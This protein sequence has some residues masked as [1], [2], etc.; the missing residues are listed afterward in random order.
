MNLAQFWGGAAAPYEIEQSLRFDGSNGYLSRTPGSAGNLRTWT[1]SVWLKRSK[2]TQVGIFCPV[3]GGDGSN[4]SQLRIKTDNTFQVYDSGAAVMNRSSTQLFRDPSAW[5]HLVVAV[6][7]TQATDTNRVKIYVNGSQIEA[8]GLLP[9]QNNDLGWNGT[10]RHDIGRYAAGAED[11]F[12]GYMAEMHHVDGTQLDPDSFGEFDDNG[13]WRPIEYTGSYGTNGFYLKF[14]PSA[15]NGIGHDH[16]GNGNNFTATGFNT[17]TG[18]G[19]WSFGTQRENDYRSGTIISGITGFTSA[20]FSGTYAW[21]GNTSGGLSNYMALR[22]SSNTVIASTSVSG[23][24]GSWS[25]TATG[26]SISTTYHLFISASSSGGSYM[27]RNSYGSFTTSYDGRASDTD[28][29][30]DTPTTNWATLN[31]LWPADVVESEGNLHGQFPNAPCKML[32]TMGMTSGKYYWEVD[33]PSF[34]AGGNHGIANDGTPVSGHTG[35][36]ANSWAYFSSGVKSNND[37]TASYGNSWTGTDIIGVAFDAD[38][39]NLYFYKNGTVQNSGT[40]AY[41]GL[42]NGPYYPAF[43][44]NS[45]TASSTVKVNFGQRDFAYTPPTGFNALN[46]A[47]LPAPTVKDG[48]DHFNTVTYAGNGGS[49]TITTGMDH[50]SGGGLL[51]I[52]NRTTTANHDVLDNVRGLN[53]LLELPSTA[54]E[55]TYTGSNLAATSTGYTLNTSSGQFNASSNNYVAWNWLAGG[56]GSSNTD[57]SITSTVSANPTAGFSIGTYTADGSNANRTVG[58]G[59]GVAPEFIIVKNRDTTGRHWLIWHKGF[60]DNDKALLFT[61]AAVADNRFGPSAPTSTVFGLYGGQGNYNSDDHVF[62]AFAGVE[63]YSKF[64]SYVANNSADGPF[65]YTGFT[66]AWVLVKATTVGDGWYIRNT[67]VNTYNP[68]SHAIDAASTAAEANYTSYPIDI[69]SNGFKFRG[70]GYG[71]GGTNTYVYAAFAE[72]PFGGAN[73][74]PSPAR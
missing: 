48:G 43:S 38:N 60:N 13:V 28:I 7:T 9:G 74:S 4:E 35:Q 51:W 44:D 17:T 27:E 68:V 20:S 55:Y 32:A 61:D 10:S 19:S 53:Q 24:S 59:L 25:L 33:Y 30:S 57:G 21:G 23:A 64:G 39:G 67:A 58:H 3:T 49:N 66:P 18:S 65:I 50:S 1:F 36:D 42:T 73:V 45:S 63:G 54:A 40:A 47:N 69:L 41:T 11:Y 5:F 12:D 31:P 56:T 29:M 14:D 16:S 22:D 37:V 26:L 71:N 46:T 8:S 70:N 6:D 2:L 52:K 34:S 15:T 62:Y 72:H